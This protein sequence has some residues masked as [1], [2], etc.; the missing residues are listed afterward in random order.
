MF[1]QGDICKVNLNPVAGHEQGNYRPV[2]IVSRDDIPLPGGLQIVIP[3]T[4]KKHGFVLELAL[5]KGMDTTGFALPFQ[6]RSLD[7]R[8]RDAHFIEHAPDDFI[9]KCCNITSQ[10]FEA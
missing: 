1:K 9:E 8:Q 6:V 10:L 7:L 3:I 5:P 4:S 2:M